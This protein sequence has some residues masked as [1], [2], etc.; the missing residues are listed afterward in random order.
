MAADLVAPAPVQGVRIVRWPSEHELLHHLS[1]TAVPRLVLVADGSEPPVA[2]DCLQDWMRATGDERELRARV[3][4][5]ALRALGH[6]HGRPQLDGSGILRVGPRWIHLA[7]K[8][9]GL[10]AVLLDRFNDHVPADELI[11]AVWPDGIP[12]RN[13]LAS[14][15]SALRSRLAWLG[16]DVRGTSTAGYSMRARVAAVAAPDPVGAEDEVDARAWLG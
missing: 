14:R 5:L 8:E 10:A 3:R 13:V 6:G 11:G 1:R 2:A 4:G 9:R 15:I 16:L 7:P 12:R